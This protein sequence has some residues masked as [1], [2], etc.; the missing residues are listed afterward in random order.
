[1]QDGIYQVKPEDLLGASEA[2]LGHA[3]F[4]QGMIDQLHGEAQRLSGQYTG[5]AALKFVTDQ[6]GKAKQIADNSVAAHTAHHGAHVEAHG[7]ALATE[8]K[9]LSTMG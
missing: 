3:K 7:I 5:S 9:N 6:L 8:A 2:S 4:T 1:M